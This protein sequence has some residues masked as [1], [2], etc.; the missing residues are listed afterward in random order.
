M[1]QFLLPIFCLAIVHLSYFSPVIAQSSEAPLFEAEVV[2]DYMAGRMSALAQQFTAYEVVDLDIQNLSRHV[3]ASSTISTFQ[4]Q[5]GSAAPLHFTVELNDM[6]APHYR[7]IATTDLGE[8]DLGR[9]P[10]N[11]Y[12]GVVDNN[13]QQITRLTIKKKEMIGY[14]IDGENERFIE[15]LSRF[16]DQEVPD[17]YF[18]VYN[19]KDIKDI[20]GGYCGVTELEEFQNHL[21]IPTPQGSMR[22]MPDCPSLLELATD[23]DWEWFQM[24]GANSNAEILTN[25]NMVEGVYI[26]TFNM[27][28]TIVFQNVWQT[29]SDPY[30]AAGSPS[31]D[32][33]A[34]IR[35][36]WEV[37]NATF[38]AV[39]RD[40]MHLFSAK[41]HGG[42]LG[43]VSGGLP[44]VCSNPSQAHGFT[45]DRNGAF[46]TTA[47]EIGHNFNGVHADGVGCG[48][49]GASI[50]CQ[51]LEKSLYF[52]AASC[53]TIGDYINANGSCI[54]N[55][56]T[57]PDA[58]CQD[59]TVQLNG[60]GNASITA[61]Q[62][63]SGSLDGCGLATPT[64]VSPGSFNCSNVGDN[65][66]T[67]TVENASNVTATCTA[68]VT[69]EDNLAPNAL[70]QN[71]TVQLDNSGNGSTSAAAVDNNSTDNCAISSTVLSKTSFN[72]SNLGDNTVTLTL[73]DENG[74]VSDCMATVIVEDNM[75]PVAV[76]LNTIV[77]IQ[78][79]GFYTLQQSDVFDAIN[80]SDNC[81]IDAVSFPPTIFDCDDVDLIFPIQVTVSDVSGN[82]DHCTSNITVKIGKALP[83]PWMTADIGV[84][85]LGNEYC[86]DPCTGPTPA[87]GEFTITGSGNNA[88]SSTTDNV[89]YAFQS[90][91]GDKM[92]TAKIE[93]IDPNGYGGLMIRESVA[94][95]AKQVSVFTNLSNILRHESRYSTNGPKQV[96]SFYKPSPMWLRLMRLGDWVF[97]YY[98]TNGINFSYVHGVYVPM[99]N[100]IEIGLASFTFLPNAQTASV[101]SFVDVENSTGLSFAIQDEKVEMDR[102]RLEPASREQLMDIQLATRK[103]NNASLYPNPTTNTFFVQFEK[104]VEEDTELCISN[105]LGQIMDRRWLQAGNQHVEWNTNNLVDGIYFLSIQNSQR[106]QQTLRLMIKRE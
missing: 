47:H 53:T 55:D 87:D 4:L 37:N 75:P 22:T 51:G 33:L 100:C 97:A 5:L 66:V 80:S 93:S 27:Q 18:V 94:D 2:S 50:M 26:S 7:A 34:E 28:F 38:M 49:E 85:T 43:S 72:C 65:T 83:A 20:P 90:V 45:A 104:S 74:N 84:V 95:G 102:L 76:C 35:E 98:S 30:T 14:F 63:N 91:C 54:V 44:S 10:C 73:T 79:D 48:M 21:D 99:S 86:F 13:N 40:L 71:V 59:I 3:R 6:R 42:L 41:N 61:A 81:G 56:G 1:K 12:K 69:V 32:I 78:P 105:Q 64:N 82:S 62:V 16:T 89:A 11:T 60:S 46:L 25:L 19:I 52:S 70:C 9:A 101:F 96:N 58:I 17:N 29:S 39:D 92:I 8:V 77:E 15:P 67:L 103:R 106:Q 68:T 23:A 31:S 88:I 24:Y 36:E 57:T